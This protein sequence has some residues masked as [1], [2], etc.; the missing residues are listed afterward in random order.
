MQT[1]MEEVKEIETIMEEVKDIETNILKTMNH[2]IETIIYLQNETECGFYIWVPKYTYEFLQEYRGLQRY[3][4]SYLKVLDGFLNQ[5]EIYDEV[6]KLIIKVEYDKILDAYHIEKVD[7]AKDKFTI[8]ANRNNERIKLEI[9][10]K[11]LEKIVDD[12]NDLNEN[13]N[14]YFLSRRFNKIISRDQYEGGLKIFEYI[15]GGHYLEDTNLKNE[16][17]ELYKKDFNELYYLI[18]EDLKKLQKRRGKIRRKKQKLLKNIEKAYKSINSLRRLHFHS[19]S[20]KTELEGKNHKPR[21][22][23][24]SFSYGGGLLLAHLKDLK[25]YTLPE[26]EKRYFVQ[27]KTSLY[28]MLKSLYNE[29]PPYEIT[30]ELLEINRL[31]KNEITEKMSLIEESILY[32]LIGAGTSAKILLSLYYLSKKQ[33]ITKLINEEKENLRSLK[34]IKE[35]NKKHKRHEIKINDIWRISEKDSLF[36]GYKLIHKLLKELGH[37]GELPNFSTEELKDVIDK[38]YKERNIIVHYLPESRAYS[39][40]IKKIKENKDILIKF[41]IIATPIIELVS[42]IIEKLEQQ[43][44]S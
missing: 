32:S 22:E 31:I 28:E 2:V 3:L 18:E 43:S 24:I 37:E 44:N 25:Y 13:S 17:K 23:K 41:L 30:N 27:F 26:E 35:G 11:D 39:N 20:I 10:Q 40:Y 29:L 34:K 5:K 12:I 15:R 14:D 21:F 33:I 7:K 38:I 9:N 4:I 19:L 42:P 6:T 1:L 36:L 16:E 8:I